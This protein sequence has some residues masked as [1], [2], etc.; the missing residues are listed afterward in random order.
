MLPL[1]Q[2]RSPTPEDII[3]P[4]EPT[5]EVVVVG[6]D[7]AVEAFDMVTNAFDRP[8]DDFVDDMFDIFPALDVKTGQVG[9]GRAG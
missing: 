8:S 7:I 2:L 5:Q 3:K 9:A 4:E 1:S 6:T